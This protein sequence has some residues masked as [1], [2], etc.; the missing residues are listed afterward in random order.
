[1]DEIIDGA[2]I[3]MPWNPVLRSHANWPPDDQGDVQATHNG[4]PLDQEIEEFVDRGMGYLERPELRKYTNFET[5]PTPVPAPIARRT[6]FSGD[7][8]NQ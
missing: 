8:S 3:R 1:M 2:N 5:N 4:K 7:G 6:S